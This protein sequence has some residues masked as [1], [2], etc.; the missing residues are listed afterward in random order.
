MKV[1]NEGTK[2]HQKNIRKQEG[3][4]G[5]VTEKGRVE[6]QQEHKSE[7]QGRAPLLVIPLL[8]DLG[9]SNSLGLCELPEL[10]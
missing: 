6:S 9:Y 1:R 3:S 10:K 2:E 5:S 4:Q 8:C 7:D